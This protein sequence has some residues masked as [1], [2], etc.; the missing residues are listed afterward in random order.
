MTHPLDPA[1]TARW[2]AWKRAHDTVL[3]AI[4]EEIR[5]VAGISVAD[6]AVLSRVIENGGGRMPSRNWA[7]CSTGSAPASPAS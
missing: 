3:E 5:H 4:G 7:P 1:E 6:F 2:T